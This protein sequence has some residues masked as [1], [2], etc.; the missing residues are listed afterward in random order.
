MERSDER[1]GERIYNV[2]LLMGRSAHGIKSW[3]RCTSGTTRDDQAAG[4]KNGKREI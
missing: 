4:G 1:E 2:E 3:R